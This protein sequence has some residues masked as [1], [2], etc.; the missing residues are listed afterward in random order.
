M[1][2]YLTAEK[3]IVDP[4]MESYI[5]DRLAAMMN[6]NLTALVGP[7]CLELKVANPEKY[8]FDP[9]RI[10]A[11]L[12]KTF[13]NLCD[14]KEFIGACAKDS[15]SYNK[16]LFTRASSILSRSNLLSYSDTIALEEFVLKVEQCVVSDQAE[17]V[18]YGDAPDEYL[19][20]F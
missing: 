5:V 17:D 16:T 20:I 12:I 11:D 6:Y 9:K 4:F 2:K 10:L 19:G 14:R 8:R 1:F 7:K 15:R 3:A 18:I 13:I